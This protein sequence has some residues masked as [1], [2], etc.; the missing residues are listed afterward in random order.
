MDL[1]AEVNE[2][3]AADVDDGVDQEDPDALDTDDED[4]VDDE[5]GIGESDGELALMRPC[6]EP[7]LTPMLSSDA[8]RA[9]LLAASK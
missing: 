3:L 5:L 8:Y 9:T 1:G 4:G 7:K 6:S 2:D